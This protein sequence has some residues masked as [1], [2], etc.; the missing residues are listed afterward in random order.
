MKQKVLLHTCCAPC[1]THAIE[2]L[3]K[4]YDVTLFFSN[5]NISPEEEYEKRFANAKKIA[6]I[7]ELELIE[8][9]Y[10]HDAWL[11]HIKGLE[12]EP[13]RGMRCA[14]CF[15]HNLKCTA[16]YA[17]NNGFDLFTTTLSISPHKDVAL[18]FG[19]GM[20]LGNFLAIDFK[21]DDGFK[22]SCDLSREHNLYRQRY[23]GCEFS[24]SK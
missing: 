19:I 7:Y 23:C 13:E 20:G 5:S 14:K 22:H 15:E 24:T 10:D 4:E 3:M 16:D 8:D 6:K 1:A 12:N 11:E 21:K 2:T 18:I 9:K 17:R